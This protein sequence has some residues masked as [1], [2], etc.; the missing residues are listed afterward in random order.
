MTARIRVLLNPEGWKV[1]KKAGVPPVSRLDAA[2]RDGRVRPRCS[3]ASVSGQ[4]PSMKCGVWISWLTS[5]RMD[6]GSGPA[7]HGCVHTGETGH[8]VRQRLKGEDVVS[9]L[10][11]IRL[12]RGVPKFLFCDNGSE[13]TSKGLKSHFRLTTVR[14]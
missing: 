2:S 1:G 10:N 11:E 6:D 9:T 7:D 4:P 13:F 5:W 12:T 8:R 14:P 3:A